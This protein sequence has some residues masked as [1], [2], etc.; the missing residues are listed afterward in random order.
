MKFILGKKIGM[1]QVFNQENQVIPVTLIEA[2]PCFVVQIKT[3]EKDGYS[4]VQIGFD[5]LND[6]K[7]KK[8]QKSKAFRYLKEFSQNGL[9]INDEINISAFNPGEIVNITGISKGKGFQGVIKRYGFAGMP[10]SHGTKHTERAPGSIGSAFPERVFKGKKMGGR[11]GSD[12]ITIQG[13]EIARV[14]EKNNLLAV[15]GAVPGKKGTLLEIIVIKEI[16]AVKEEK[17]GKLMADLEKQ[18]ADAGK[19][20]D[21]K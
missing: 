1:T 3:K 11:M 14:D 18:E 6:K 12:K 19:K 17:E 20:K 5:K 10:A 21:A 8:S 4:A 2:G 15:K 9:K 13:L 7:I 16:E